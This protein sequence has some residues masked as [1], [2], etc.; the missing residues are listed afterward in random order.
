MLYYSRIQEVA[1]TQTRACK[2]SVSPL[3]SMQR[4]RWWVLPL[5]CQ[6]WTFTSSR[7]QPHSVARRRVFLWH[8]K[9]Q[10]ENKDHNLSAGQRS[11][12]QGCFSHQLLTCSL[13]LIKLLIFS[14]QCHF[15]PVF[16]MFGWR[17]PITRCLLIA[18]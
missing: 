15:L 11:P 9:L 6:P 2:S 18:Q 13:V 10:L 7:C 14:P 17:L 1:G 12:V 5:I 3:Q 16:R 8:R 4:S